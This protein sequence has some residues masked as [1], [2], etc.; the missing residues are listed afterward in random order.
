MFSAIF[1]DSLTHLQLAGGV[2]GPPCSSFRLHGWEMKF[3]DFGGVKRP[4]FSVAFAVS[5]PWSG[6]FP[7]CITQNTN[8]F[9]HSFLKLLSWLL[10]ITHGIKY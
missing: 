3:L 2:F 5:G 10:I 7:S 1:T 6:V 8:T 4:F 9:D